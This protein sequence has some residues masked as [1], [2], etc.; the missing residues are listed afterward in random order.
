MLSS[1][2]LSSSC[3][4]LEPTLEPRSCRSFLAISRLTSTLKR[5]SYKPLILWDKPFSWSLSFS[6]DSKTCYSSFSVK[7][8]TLKLSYSYWTRWLSWR[9]MSCWLMCA[10]PTRE[11]SDLIWFSS[12]S[13]LLFNWIADSDKGMLYDQRGSKFLYINSSEKSSRYFNSSNSF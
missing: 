9:G 2:F 11:L 1:S 10:W 8:R 5:L 3:I 12:I 4:S 7:E 13:I 6:L